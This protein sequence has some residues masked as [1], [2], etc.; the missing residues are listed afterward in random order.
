MG[1]FDNVRVETPNSSIDTVKN[2]LNTKFDLLLNWLQNYPKSCLRFIS[3]LEEDGFM[4]IAQLVYEKNSKTTDSIVVKKDDNWAWSFYL[5]NKDGLF[6]KSIKI[7]I[8]EYCISHDTVIKL[9]IE[10]HIQTLLK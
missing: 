7:D 9:N 10:N 4:P 2:I 5:K 8:H 1:L 6:Y 3:I